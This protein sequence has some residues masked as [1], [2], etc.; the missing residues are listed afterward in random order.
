[1]TIIFNPATNTVSIVLTDAEKAVLIRAMQDHGQDVV[2]QIFVN[3]LKDRE[4]YQEDADKTTFRQKFNAL[5]D[6]DKNAILA[7]LNK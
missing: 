7:L 1:M 3:W 6:A 2:K 5:S 4:W